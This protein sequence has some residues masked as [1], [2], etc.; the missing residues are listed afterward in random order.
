[1]NILVVDDDIAILELICIIVENSYSEANIVRA[2]CPK[3][4]IIEL[5][6]VNFDLIICDFEMPPFGTGKEVYDHLRKSNQQTHF[7]LF[8]SRN[9]LEIEFLIAN[10]DQRLAS[11]R[12]PARP[13]DIKSLLDKLL[14]YDR[15][16]KQENYKKIPI[17]NFTR[18]NYTNCPVYIEINKE[19]YVK[20]LN[21]DQDYDIEF[22]QRY[23]KKEIKY[24]YITEGDYETFLA[25]FTSN[26]FLSNTNSEK[27]FLKCAKS[28]H[29]YLAGLIQGIGLSQFTLDE[30]SKL[31]LNA[32]EHGLNSSFKSIIES[33]ITSNDYSYDHTYLITC[34]CTHIASEIGLTKK[35]TERLANAALIHDLGIVRSDLNYIH[36]IRPELIDELPLDEQFTI[37]KHVKLLENSNNFEDISD[38]IQK[39]LTIHHSFDENYPYNESMPNTGSSL[40]V[41]TFLVA[42]AF[43][44]ELYRYDFEPEK[45]REIFTILKYKFEQKQYYKI[46]KAIEDRFLIV[47]QE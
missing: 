10:P 28:T 8:T 34:I 7:L 26:G 5:D 47:A 32:I 12:K 15:A 40:I 45:L 44:N 31:S 37:K 36:D 42:H 41:S 3:T 16:A 46:I 25:E 22:I 1:M 30:S 39:I 33:L 17:Y 2:S 18:F 29:L 14:N 9:I 23:I 19:K 4:A 24:F 20:I 6:K 27:D 43:S 13:K 38:E 11:L 35:A 21:K